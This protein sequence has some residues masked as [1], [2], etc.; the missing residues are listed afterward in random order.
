MGKVHLLDCTLR[1]GGYVND[2]RFGDSAIKSIVHSLSTAN[3]EIIEIGF[4]RDEANVSGRTVWSSMESLSPYLEQGRKGQQFAVMGEIFNPLPIEKIEP[5]SDRTPDIIRVIVWKR[6]ITEAIGYL[7]K[8]TELGYKVCVQPERAN[9]YTIDE[10]KDLIKAFEC[11]HPMAI[12]VVDSNGLMNKNRLMEYLLAAD[13]VM[14][15]YMMLGYHGHNNLLQAEG[16]AEAFAELNLARDII[17]D[18]SVFGIGRSS[19]NL[20]IEIFAK[21]MNEKYSTNYKISNMLKVYEDYIADIYREKPWGYSMETFV[22]AMHECNPNYAA[23]LR[24]EYKCKPSEIDSIISL[25][26]EEDKVITNREA[27]KKY[28]TMFHEN[29]QNGR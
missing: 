21:Y 29:G 2:W 22:T 25:M 6:K 20:N 1:D 24:D 9:Q 15:P 12:Y 5:H 28:I 23:I 3:I 10:F 16:V 8:I 26:S 4:M 13:E 7:K 17:I 19:G 18:G 11:V 27:V 14:P